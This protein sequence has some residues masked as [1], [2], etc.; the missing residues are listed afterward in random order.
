MKRNILGCLMPLF[1]LCIC[2]GAC[3]R[4]TATPSRNC[5]I[6]SLVIDEASFPI[7][8]F[9]TDTMSP[10]PSGLISTSPKE[11]VLRTISVRQ[12]MASQV[13]FRYSSV[14]EAVLDFQQ[15]R[16]REFSVR[17]GTKGSG[18]P[19]MGPWETPEVLTY[20]SSIANQ[21]YVGCG[22]ER[23]IYRCKLIA[24]YEEY[25]ITDDFHMDR[26]PQTSGLTFQELGSVL[27]AI[28]EKMAGCL[29]KTLP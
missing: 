3:A 27:R 24:V 13:I 1:I 9:V 10:V 11:S 6:T 18:P 12:G 26:P 19:P 16:Q 21:Y 7:G 22:E 14:D 20:H 28:D 25:Y 17:A 2:I 29:G 5:P 15:A 23:F 4:S 8:A